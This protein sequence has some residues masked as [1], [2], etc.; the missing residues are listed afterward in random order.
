MRLGRS[1][2]LRGLDRRG[3]GVDVVAVVDALGVPAVGVEPLED[4]LADQAIDVGP[5]SWMW[6]SS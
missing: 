4:V 3:D 6:L 5:S 1:S 2:A